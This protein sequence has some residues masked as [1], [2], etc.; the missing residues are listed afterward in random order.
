MKAVI[1]RIA[2]Y[3]RHNLRRR[4]THDDLIEARLKQSPERN[5]LLGR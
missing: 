5:Y 3:I 4:L 1:R 2:L